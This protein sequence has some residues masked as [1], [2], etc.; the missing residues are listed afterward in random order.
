MSEHILDPY[1]RMKAEQLSKIE[2]ARAVFP[3]QFHKIDSLM[4]V[5]VD[6]DQMLFDDK[7]HNLATG[8]AQI[9]ELFPQ[10]SEDRNVA[11]EHWEEEHVG[12]L[13]EWNL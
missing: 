13:K 10:D 4:H 2:R 5:Q 7:V 9:L 3:A 12:I 11:I 8:L 6:H 1:H